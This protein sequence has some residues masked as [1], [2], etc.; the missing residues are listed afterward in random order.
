MILGPRSLQLGRQL[1]RAVQVPLPR[2][3]DLAL[4]DPLSSVSVEACSRTTV[5]DAPV[6]ASR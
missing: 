6:T 2:Q 3:A 1:Q 4:L 5:I